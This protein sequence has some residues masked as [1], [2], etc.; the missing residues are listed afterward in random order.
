MEYVLIFLMYIGSA[1]FFLQKLPDL[2]TSTQND[3]QIGLKSFYFISLSPNFWCFKGSS[4][5]NFAL[6]WHGLLL[7]AWNPIHVD[8]NQMHYD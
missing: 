7:Y 6:D 3:E 4:V 8:L 2:D 5:R 1:A